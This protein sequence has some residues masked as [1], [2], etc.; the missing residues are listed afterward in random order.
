MNVDLFKSL[1]RPY[2]NTWSVNNLSTAANRIATAYDL[3]NIGES[4]PFFGAKLIKG[5]KN[6]LQQFLSNGLILNYSLTTELPP[7]FVEPGFTLM[8]TGFCMYWVSSA[9]TP[10]PPMPPMIA[11]TTGVTVLFPGVPI[12]LDKAIKKECSKI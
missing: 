8:A 5:N 3:A 4:G 10:L 6:I 12:G 7:P 2:W 11:P 1:L 9:F